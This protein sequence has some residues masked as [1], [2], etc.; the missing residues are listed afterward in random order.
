MYLTSLNAFV[1]AETLV[2]KGANVNA[3]DSNDQNVLFYLLDLT[4]YDMQRFLAL[5]LKHEIDL[6]QKSICGKYFLNSVIEKQAFEIVQLVLDSLDAS[7][8]NGK[9]TLGIFYKTEDEKT[10]ILLKEKLGSK[11]FKYFD[12]KF[13]K[14]SRKLGSS[15]NSDLS[16]SL[17]QIKFSG[18]PVLLCEKL[19]FNSLKIAK[20][21]IHK[22]ISP[23]IHFFRGEGEECQSEETPGIKLA[24]HKTNLKIIPRMT[25]WLEDQSGEPKVQGWL[26]D[27]IVEMPIFEFKTV[28]CIQAKPESK[29]E[30]N[31]RTHY[32]SE[33]KQE[34]LAEFHVREIENVF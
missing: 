24:T 20:T 18:T 13:L 30:L 11:H 14:K 32:L 21:E 2:S 33:N 8:K 27:Q 25:G 28:D 26:D 5:F 15:V 31:V 1:V 29:P 12:N 34:I 22:V 19:S 7:T 6:N 10:R 23:G 4:A 16:T 17:L 3:L 9:T